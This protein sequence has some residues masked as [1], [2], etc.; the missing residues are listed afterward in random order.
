M[1]LKVRFTKYKGLQS[2]TKIHHTKYYLYCFCLMVIIM[3]P[4]IANNRITE[5]II[6]QIK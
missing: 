4:T 6:N 2:K 5:V 1:Q 3:D